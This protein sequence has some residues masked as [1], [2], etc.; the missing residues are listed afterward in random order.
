MFEASSYHYLLYT[1]RH[2][3]FFLSCCISCVSIWKSSQITRLTRL[4][5]RQ[6]PTIHLLYP[7][8]LSRCTGQNQQ[9]ATA[10]LFQWLHCPTTRGQYQIIVPVTNI[11]ERIKFQTRASSHTSW[12]S[13]TREDWW[14]PTIVLGFRAA[15]HCP[16]SLLHCMQRNQHDLSSLRIIFHINSLKPGRWIM[17]RSIGLYHIDLYNLHALDWGFLTSWM[18][19]IGCPQFV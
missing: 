12:V 10:K 1:I 13:S 7:A 9:Q 11:S 17:E 15:F 16:L 2:A 6:K 19:D 3:A 14:K 18:S 8:H 4:R 5:V